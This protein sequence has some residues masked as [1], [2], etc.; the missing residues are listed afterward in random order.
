[1]RDTLDHIRMLFIP[2]SGFYYTWFNRRPGSRR[3]YSRIDRGMAN[4]KWWELFPNASL[5]ILPQLTSN[6][7]PQ[8]LYCFGHQSFSRKPFRFEATWVEDQRSGWVINQAWLSCSHP[9]LPTNLLNPLS[10][11][12]VALSKWSKCQFGRIQTNIKA[13]RDAL[14]KVQH[15]P[16]SNVV[17][18]TDSNLRLHLENLLKMEEL[19]WFQKSRLKWQLEGD[20]CTRY[21]FLSTLMRRKSNRIDC[22]KDTTGD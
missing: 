7:N 14:D 20:R 1:M 15:A 19:L 8:V 13:T 5:K 6:H 16:D 10:A 22:L 4:E 11:T 18:D 2:S 21:F 3:V 17:F 9:H 12:Q